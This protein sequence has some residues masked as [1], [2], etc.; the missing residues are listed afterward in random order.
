MYGKPAILDSV[1]VRK[2]KTLQ[3]KTQ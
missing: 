1:R 2:R 3:T